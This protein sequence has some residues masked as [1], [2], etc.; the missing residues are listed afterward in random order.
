MV[1]AWR[2]IAPY[3]YPELIL[4]VL[5]AIVIYG[6]VFPDTLFA[7][8]LS[9]DPQLQEEFSN[10]L[11]SYVGIL[12]YIPGSESASGIVFWGAI[13]AIVYLLIALMINLVLLI[14][15]Q[16]SFFTYERQ[17]T[18]KRWFAYSLF[19]RSIWVWQHCR[20]RIAILIPHI[21]SGSGFEI[22]DIRVPGYCRPQP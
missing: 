12:N 19:R 22:C 14:L 8:F 17:T 2:R 6:A 13:G 16:F 10:Q 9:E 3:N 18:G 15:R 1:S 7:T 4:L 5:L 21:L 11:R 20:G